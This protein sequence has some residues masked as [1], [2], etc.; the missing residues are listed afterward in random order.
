MTQLSISQVIDAMSEEP[1]IYTSFQTSAMPVLGILHKCITDLLAVEGADEGACRALKEK[2]CSHTFNILVVGQFNRGKTT[3][4]NALIGQA[5]LPVGVIPLTSVVTVLSYGE[6]SAVKVCLQSGRCVETTPESLC[7]YVTEKGNPHNVKGVREVDVSF[8][9]PWLQDGVRLVDTPGIGSVYRHNTDVAYRYLPQADAVLFLLSADQPV[10]RTELDF[11]RDVREYADRIFFLLNKADYLSESELQEAV[12]FTQTVIKEAVEQEPFI[13][14]VSARLALEGR[15][16]DSAELVKKSLLPLF[17]QTLH[18]FLQKEK[19]EVLIGSV[20]RSLLRIISQTRF[21]LELEQKS[22]AVS[23]SELE[24]KIRVFK[25]KK[26]EVEAARDEYGVILASE[27][28]KLQQQTEEEL[29]TFKEELKQAM[30]TAV[31]NFYRENRAM[32]P[33]TLS[34]HL[35]QYVATAIRDEFDIWRTVEDEKL[36]ASFDLLCARFTAR[37]NETV[38]ELFRFSADLFAIPFSAVRAES[39]RSTRSGFYYKF[40]S[41]PGSMKLFTSSLLLALPKFIGD[42]MLLKKMREY[43][44]DCVEVQSGRLRHDFAQRLEKS[45]KTF[46]REMTARLETTA[47]SIEAAM[48]K[49]MKQKQGDEREAETRQIAIRE[50]LDRLSEISDELALISDKLSDR[51]KRYGA[52]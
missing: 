10:S 6:T 23:L 42:R 48:A 19:G 7:E 21:S 1:G 12:T 33:R 43:A 41:E 4:I 52:D 2:L 47:M 30:I 13:V 51:N 37:I 18:T 16:T 3:L 39:L 34:E 11:L 50:R 45:A 14:P 9:S 24:E 20:V 32:P 28:K 46:N 31:E 26:R 49:G 44:V 40:W 27:S 17:F 29:N 5:L 38:D 15:L 36:S 8:P 25:E 35:E 22:S